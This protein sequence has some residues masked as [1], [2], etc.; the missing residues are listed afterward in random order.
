MKFYTNVALMGNNILV[1]EYDNGTRKNMRVPYE[2]TLFV[3]S[4]KQSKFKTLEGR[5]VSPVKQGSINDARDFLR[6]YDNVAG[7]EIYGNTNYQYCYVADEY[8]G[9]I[10]Y[11]MNQ[12]V[13]ANFDIETGSDNG[14]PQPDTALEPVISITIKTQG[15]YHVL[16]YGDYTPHQ[17]DVNWIKCRDEADLLLRFLDLW[18]EIQ[19]DIMTG[20]NIQFFDIPYLVNRIERILGSDMV[21]KL[22]PWGKVGTRQTVMNG[23]DQTIYDLIGIG[24]L[25][26]YELYRKFAPVSNHESYRLDY[27]ANYELGT[28]KLDYSEYGSLHTLYKSNYQ[29][30]IEYNVKDVDLVDQLENKMK[31]LEMAVSLAYDAKVNYQ[32]VYAQVRMWDTLI[33]NDFKQKKIVMPS[34]KKAEKS[35]S[36]SGAYVKEPI[37][38]MHE[39]V[40]SFDLNSLYPHLIM[41]YNI[42]PET[43]LDG[44]HMQVDVDGL[45]EQNF[46]L[47][48]LQ[49]ENATVTPNG[50]M[51]DKSQQ[52]FLPAMMERMYNDRKKYKKM[53]LQ[54]LDKAEREHDPAKKAEYKRLASAY[55]NTQLAKKVQLNSAYGALGNQYF[56]FYDLRMAEAITYGGQLS[57]RWIANDVNKWLNNMLKTDGEDYVVASDTDSIYVRFGGLVNQVFKKRSD[58]P[59]DDTLKIVQFLDRAAEEKIEPFI[60]KSYQNLATYVNAYAQKMQMKREA[61]ADKAIWQAKKRYIL[62]VWDNE[63]VRYEKA[64]L[65]MSGIEAVKSSTPTVCRDRIKHAL[66]L[67]MTAN[68][69][70]IQ[71]YV[72]NFKEE[73]FE[74]PLNDIAFPRGC[75]GV[76]K[77]SDSTSVYIKGTPMHVKGAIVYNKLLRDNKL[78]KK[79]QIVQ[80]GDKIKFLYMREPNPSTVGCIS[81]PSDG[82]LPEEFL[83][84]KYVNKDEQFAKSF[85]EPLD[86]ILNVIG[87]NAEQ[88]ASLEDL[89]I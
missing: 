66:E 41:Q 63:G 48:S 77:Y 52:G 22:S 86:A 58:I 80:E 15:V 42:S 23:R 10:D 55:N 12:L 8:P 70:T 24:T 31:L 46:D 75:N 20:W 6:Q 78:T 40:M 36:Y 3:P 27:I 59:G 16:G 32:D 89:F 18:D 81:F 76:K 37:V 72:A 54:E 49:S 84:T 47:T 29:L 34:K 62:N 79:Y 85:V 19:P 73:F 21:R 44:R 53:M 56:R 5:M 51:F 9:M 45:L 14:F 7:F 25:D 87:W 74:L 39:W 13:I 35:A 1:R 67:I 57:I 11:D 61:I 50:V 82:T 43:L 33:F 4:N 17:D 71:N 26:Y 88:K 28:G 65:K 64:K 68:E 83:L 69:K 2:P 30:F 38:G 60:D